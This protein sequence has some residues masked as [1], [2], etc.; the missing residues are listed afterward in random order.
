MLNHPSSLG[1]HRGLFRALHLIAAL[2]LPVLASAQET[3]AVA[4]RVADSRTGYSLQGAIIR[5]D[6]SSAVAYSD[7]NGRFRLAGLPAGNR[8]LE[9]EYVGLD[10]LRRSVALTAGTTTEIEL[11]L[12]SRLRGD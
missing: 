3:A 8:A 7:A 6:G 1:S 2:L 10:P 5:V 9:V 4:G 11:R 12:E